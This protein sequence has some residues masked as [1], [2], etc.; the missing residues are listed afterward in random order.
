MGDDSRSELITRTTVAITAGGAGLAG[1]DWGALATAMTP[2][3]EM[4][5]A[6]VVGFIG[7]RRHG[8]VEE[9]VTVAADERSQSVEDLLAA[10]VENDENHELFVRVVTVAQDTA[11]REK[12]IALGRALAAGLDGDE[13]AVNDELLFVRAV[14]DLDAP[15]IRLLSVMNEP[16]KGTGQMAEQ[17]LVDGWT[18]AILTPAVPL[19]ARHLP[20]LLAT[21]GQ[22]G[23]ITSES[24]ATWE[25][26]DA[27]SYRITDL[28]RSTLQRLAPRQTPS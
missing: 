28:G 6:R 11:L 15:H 8:H 16:R 20:S 12:R 27:R 13:S 2:A 24:L 26:L 9:A 10:A 5:L 18:E 23:L 19:L 25:G 4:A 1:P 14:A 7:R 17:S 3:A 22:H 21:L